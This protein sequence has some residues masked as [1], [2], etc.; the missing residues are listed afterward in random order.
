M[1]DVLVSVHTPILRSGRAV[2][3]Y[4]VARA[5]AAVGDGLTYVYVRF[6]GDE[7]DAAHRAIPGIRFAPVEPSRGR[8]PPARLRRRAGAWRAG[9][10]RARRLAG[11]RRRRAAARARSGHAA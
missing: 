5:L 10:L 6:G 11:A 2:R 7:P 3:T 4:G 9:R 1:S 8:A